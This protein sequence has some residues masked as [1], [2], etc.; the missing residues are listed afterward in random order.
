MK[1]SL[2]QVQTTVLTEKEARAIARIMN[3]EK[4]SASVQFF[5]IVSIY[6]WNGQSEE[7]EE[8]LIIIKSTQSKFEKIKK[9]LE[10]LHSYELPQ[11][12]SIK[13]DNYSQEYSS[14]IIKET[15]E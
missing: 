5:P 3:E 14:W 13:I 2:I 9:R 6:T 10:E 12:T 8:F 11:I 15:R 4:L 1:D 7:S